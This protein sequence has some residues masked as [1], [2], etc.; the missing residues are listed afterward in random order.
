MQVQVLLRLMSLS[1]ISYLSGILSKEMVLD[2]VYR[3]RL[4]VL[5]LFTILMSVYLTLVYSAVIF[6]SLFGRGGTQLGYSQESAL[7]VVSTIVNTLL[8]VCSGVWLETNYTSPHTTVVYG[9]VLINLGVLLITLC[10]LS[11]IMRYPWWSQ[12][13]EG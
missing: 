1:G 2:S 11:P 13:L 12:C 5:L 8:V 4:K 10:V 9:E 6:K 3:I 7:V